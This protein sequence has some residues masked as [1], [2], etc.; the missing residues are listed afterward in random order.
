MADRFGI[1]TKSLYMWMAQ[2]SKPLR[3]TDHEAEVRR[4]KKE[5]VCVTEERDI[6][7]KWPPRTSPGMQCEVRVYQ[8]ALRAASRPCSLQDVERSSERILCMD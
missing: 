1:S 5:M 2:F 3:Q 7:K 4:L 6:P 8:R